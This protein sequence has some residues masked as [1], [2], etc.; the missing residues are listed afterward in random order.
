VFV[1]VPT[2][3]F[4]VELTVCVRLFTVDETDPRS[5]LGSAG[6][7]GLDSVD[8]A[9]CSNEP[10][11]EVVLPAVLVPEEVRPVWATGW[12]DAVVPVVDDVEVVDPPLEEV[13]WL[14]AVDF[15]DDF[16][17]AVRAVEGARVRCVRATPG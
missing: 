15:A 14:V 16:D 7:L 17:F 13:L 6:S 2:V 9:D 8:V 4:T 10:A 3:L 5:T 1:S 12:L 11:L